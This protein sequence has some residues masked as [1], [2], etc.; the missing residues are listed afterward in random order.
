MQLSPSINKTSRTYGWNSEVSL[1][2]TVGVRRSTVCLVVDRQRSIIYFKIQYYHYFCRAKCLVELFLLYVNGQISAGPAKGA[3]T[4]K[5]RLWLCAG[6]FLTM[7]EAHY[8]WLS[9]P[10][11]TRCQTWY[12]VKANPTR[13][14]F[15]CR[16]GA[17]HFKVAA[18]CVCWLVCVCVCSVIVQIRVVYIPHADSPRNSPML[19]RSCFA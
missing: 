15:L 16:I 13:S 9:W 18:E 1:P 5:I 6:I 4:H 2:N 19:C 10:N 14:M 11:L 3:V 12:E 7:C 8:F 17:V